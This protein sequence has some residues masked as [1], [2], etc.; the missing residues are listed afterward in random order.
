V[1]F[2][3]ELRTKRYKICPNHL[4]KLLKNNKLLKKQQSIHLFIKIVYCTLY[5]LSIRL[6]Q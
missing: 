1:V 3:D 2:Q 5:I 4:Q 6:T